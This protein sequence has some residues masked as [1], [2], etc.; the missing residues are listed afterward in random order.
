MKTVDD[1]LKGITQ[2][3]RHLQ[4][5]YGKLDLLDTDALAGNTII[6]VDRQLDD[7]LDILQDAERRT[8]SLSR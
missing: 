1:Y 5:V 7:L 8:T 4:K 6:E 2:K 3:A